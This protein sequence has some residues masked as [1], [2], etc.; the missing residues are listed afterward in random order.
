M[1]TNRTS[2]W[3]PVLAL[4]ALVNAALERVAEFLREGSRP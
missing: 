3:T 1:G 4:V 2:R